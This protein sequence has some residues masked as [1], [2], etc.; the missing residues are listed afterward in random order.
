MLRSEFKFGLS[1]TTYCNTTLYPAVTG[2][3]KE[4]VYKL[5]EKSTVDRGQTEAVISCLSHSFAVV[6]GPPGT[7]KSYIGAQSIQI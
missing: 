3:M 1:R 6:Q 4:V 2:I 5:T 7:G